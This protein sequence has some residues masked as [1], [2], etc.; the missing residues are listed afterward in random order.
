MAPPV[1]PRPVEKPVPV[2]AAA[3]APGAAAPEVRGL[4]G[5]APLPPPPPIKP[6]PVAPVPQGALVIELV[7]RID[8]GTL[9]LRVDDQ[10]VARENFSGRGGRSRWKKSYHVPAGRRRVEIRVRGDGLDAIEGLD[11]DVT[12]GGHSA[13]EVSFTPLT[14]RLRIRPI[15]PS[16]VRK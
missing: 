9:N 11:V 2:A 13:L 14:H 10:E 4:F 16:E 7:H 3:A 12:E 6:A 15:D 5:F 8:R 1:A